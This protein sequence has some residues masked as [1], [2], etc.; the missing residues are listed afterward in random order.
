MQSTH[1]PRSFASGPVWVHRACIRFPVAR[2]FG[3]ALLLCAATAAAWPAQGQTVDLAPVADAAIYEPDDD[4]S[5]PTVDLAANGRGD[6]LFV[7]RTGAPA[8]LLLRRSLLRFDVA[9]ALPAGATIES[10]TLSLTVDKVPDEPGGFTT[11]LQALDVS[12][13][14]GPTES[15]PPGGAGDPAATGDVT[16]CD[17]E[18][19]TAQWTTAGGDF[20]VE[21]DGSVLMTGLGS[22]VFPSSPAMVAT[23][24]SWLD[25]PANNHGWVVR[26]GESFVRSAKRLVSREAGSGGPILTLTYSVA[27]TSPLDVP[28]GRTAGLL[29]ILALAWCGARWLRVN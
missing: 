15:P 26:G 8:G 12:W 10:A 11:R 1:L 28:V 20:G 9:S 19:G 3:W 6:G 23:V 17:R 16:W 4:C 25:D 22:Y 2:Q 21:V 5:S 18:V 13:N 7:G 14:E 24:Q 27:P 29:L